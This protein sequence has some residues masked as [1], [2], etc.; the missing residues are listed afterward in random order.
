MPARDIKRETLDARKRESAIALELRGAKADFKEAKA[1]YRGA[2]KE[3]DRI[4]KIHENKIRNN[5]PEN[6]MERNRIDVTRNDLDAAKRVLDQKQQAL[7]MAEAIEKKYQKEL[8]Q[9]LQ[10]SRNPVSRF[11]AWAT[12][13]PGRIFDRFLEIAVVNKE[14]RR[15][16]KMPDAERQEE[17]RKMRTAYEYKLAQDRDERVDTT[18]AKEYILEHPESGV[19]GY[20]E[21]EAADKEMVAMDKLIRLCART[22]ETIHI[23]LGEHNILKLE[24]MDD[25]VS[26]KG[27]YVAIKLCTP[28]RDEDGNSFLL[29]DK[30]I[31]HFHVVERINGDWSI[32]MQTSSRTLLQGCMEGART[33][34][35]DTIRMP[36]KEEREIIAD[37]TN[38]DLAIRRNNMIAAYEKEKEQQK[39]NSKGTV[40]KEENKKEESQKD[41]KEKSVVTPE[42]KTVGKQALEIETIEKDIREGI[43]LLHDEYRADKTLENHKEPVA[44]EVHG[45][46]L[47]ICPGKDGAFYKVDDQY[48]GKYMKSNR[49]PDIIMKNILSHNALDNPIAR[50]ELEG[51]NNLQVAG[52]VSK[53]LLFDA[54][55]GTKAAAEFLEANKE[56]VQPVEINEK[57]VAE[58]LKNDITKLPESRM[59]EVL[60]SIFDGVC[61]AEVDDRL[62]QQQ[63]TG[64][65]KEA[66]IN[67]MK[68][69]G[70]FHEGQVY[71]EDVEFVGQDGTLYDCDGR[72][73][74][75]PDGGYVTMDNLK[76]FCPEDILED[77]IKELEAIRECSLGNIQEPEVVEDPEQDGW[78]G[79]KDPNELDAMEQAP[80]EPLFMEQQDASESFAENFAEQ[81]FFDMDED[82]AADDSWMSYDEHD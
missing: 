66:Y 62:A 6:E 55:H 1:A 68:Q 21:L 25:Q 60:K 52:Y 15:L 4:V 40:E 8:Y 46:Q 29:E 44:I 45:Y 28:G 75:R 38:R 64:I 2:E 22:Q 30:D 77:T 58:F 76:D 59:T 20:D 10:R 80:E 11:L 49:N 43:Q 27:G 9:S 79:I 57:K 48:V 7:N 19:K 32:D 5:L 35:S 54:V 73:F 81:N 70:M 36:S 53:A 31:G 14:T 72:L 39:E 78:H 41:E 3:L 65:Y 71:L 12:S 24:F 74:Q 47:S 18:R 51:K 82:Y 50:I 67:T 42:T 61:L 37:V 23:G 63:A 34:N 13:I 33:E 69:D 56:S 16:Q 26:D 17:I